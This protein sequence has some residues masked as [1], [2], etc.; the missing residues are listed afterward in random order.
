M[1]TRAHS[2]ISASLLLV[3]FAAIISDTVIGH[4]AFS[5]APPAIKPDPYAVL[6]QC[7][8]ELP[9]HNG[10]TTA[11][12]STDKP[13]FL[14]ERLEDGTFSTKFKGWWSE[15]G[16]EKPAGSDFVHVFKADR[17]VAIRNELLEKDGAL[18]ADLLHLHATGSDA[19]S[20]KL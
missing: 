4:R 3:F 20:C 9:G 5:D 2:V 12:H 6:S 1:V 18:A 16:P 7:K 13:V 15:G 19:A 17:I 11:G 14:L 10:N 8:L